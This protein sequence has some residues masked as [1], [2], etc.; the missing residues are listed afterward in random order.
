MKK[1]KIKIIVV[2]ILFFVLVSSHIFN[3]GKGHVGV[4]KDNIALTDKVNGLT[5]ENNGLKKE[6]TTLETKVSN[7]TTL[8]KTLKT[9]NETIKENE[10]KD[11]IENLKQKSKNKKNEKGVITNSNDA[12]SGFSINAISDSEDN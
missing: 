1:A 8:N 5:K 11:I 12:S 6:V 4:V 10:K 3:T 9:N 2:L 7:L